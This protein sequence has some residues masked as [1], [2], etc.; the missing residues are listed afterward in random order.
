MVMSLALRAQIGGKCMMVQLWDPM[1][2]AWDFGGW[3]EIVLNL[4]IKANCYLL[5]LP[6]GSTKCD[7]KTK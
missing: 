3:G 7:I 4:K 1:I 2:M 6:K 5:L